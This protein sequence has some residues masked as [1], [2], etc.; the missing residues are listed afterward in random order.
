MNQCN[1]PQATPRCL[2]KLFYAVS[3]S[4]NSGEIMGFWKFHQARAT[5]LRSDFRYETSKRSYNIF[6]TNYFAD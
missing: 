1:L 6:E 3:V 4:Y 5:A 2:K